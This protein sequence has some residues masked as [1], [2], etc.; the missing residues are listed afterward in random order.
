MRHLTSRAFAPAVISNFFAIHDEALSLRPPDFSKVGATGGGFTL[1]KGVCT[2]ASL[3]R[4]PRNS[5]S[6]SVNGDAKYPARTTRKTVELLLDG[7]DVPPQ[8]IELTQVVEV[9]IGAGFGSSSASAL[10]AAM[11]VASALELELTK[12]EVASFAH[13]ADIECHTGLGTVSSTFDHSGAGIVT[14]AGGPGVAQVKR[15]RVPSGL[16]VVTATLPLMEGKAGALSSSA[17]RSRVNEL[18][19]RALREALEDPSFQN[20]V[21]VGRRFSRGLGLETPTARKLID[22]CMRSGAVGASQN[23]VGNAMHAAVRL[24]EIESVTRS[25]ISTST[26]ARIDVFSIGGKRARLLS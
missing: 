14:K 8:H 18:G 5:I 16:R 25:L 13:R 21:A 19:E 17:V 23:M 12:E 1:S 15:L 2:E 3:F 22:I 10:S 11:A 24:D 20:L 9:P 7:A 26:E 6:V 4:A